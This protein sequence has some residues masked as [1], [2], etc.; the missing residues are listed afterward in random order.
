[1][2]IPPESHWVEQKASRSLEKFE[3][4]DFAKCIVSSL[5]TSSLSFSLTLHLPHFPLTPRV[6]PSL[7][8]FLLTP[9]FSHSS[10]HFVLS[11]FLS[12]SFF[13]FTQSVQLLAAVFLSRT[14]FWRLISTRTLLLAHLLVFLALLHPLSLTIPCLSPP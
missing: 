10:L 6:P 5:E 3:S 12:C 4:R 2:R 13:P 1:M 14:L 9:R 11:L 8:D 7:P